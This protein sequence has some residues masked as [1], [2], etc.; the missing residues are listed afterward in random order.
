MFT[1]VMGRLFRPQNRDGMD[2]N[3][4]FGKGIFF[5]TNEGIDNRSVGACVNVD[6]NDNAQ[7]YSVCCC[8]LA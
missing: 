6:G 5:S 1:E 3:K 8:G 2:F 7:A 4:A